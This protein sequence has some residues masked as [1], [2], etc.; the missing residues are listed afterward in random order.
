MFHVINGH[1]FDNWSN[2][3]MQK[4][5]L[6]LSPLYLFSLG[7][8]ALGKVF[9]NLCCMK[10]NEVVFLSNICVFNEI[11]HLF[12]CIGFFVTNSWKSN[13]MRW[14]FQK[15]VLKSEYNQFMTVENEW[16]VSNANINFF[17]HSTFIRIEKPPEPVQIH[18]RKT[19]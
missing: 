13:L 16:K 7:F 11:I 3:S 6:C 15:Y 17:S 10:S 5:L 14:D 9:S 18:I 4:M 8:Q 2:A 12:L 1:I 19:N